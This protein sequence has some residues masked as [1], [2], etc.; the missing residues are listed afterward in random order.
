M[1]N[2]KDKTE[3]VVIVEDGPIYDNFDPDEETSNEDNSSVI[4][5]DGE[6]LEDPTE[7][8]IIEDDVDQDESMLSDADIEEVKREAEAL[9]VKPII[10]NAEI[11]EPIESEFKT[12]A[13]IERILEMETNDAT[14]TI[15]PSQQLD[16][17]IKNLSTAIANAKAD[18]NFDLERT[19]IEVMNGIT[20]TGDSTG[21]ADTLCRN[22]NAKL[23]QGLF[24]PQTGQLLGIR[25]V[26]VGTRAE[27]IKGEVA[28]LKAA[29]ALNLGDVVHVPLP[30]SGFWVTLTPPSE[31]ELIRFYNSMAR[32]KTSLGRSSQG[33]IFGN[34]SVKLNYDLFN[35]IKR[36][37]M[38]VNFK[39]VDKKD[40][41]DKILINDLPILVWG[42]ART[43]YANGF[44]FRRLCDNR[45]GLDDNGNVIP[46]CDDIQK[47]NMSLDK[48]FWLDNN[49]LSETQK[50]IFSKN[51]AK[52]I[53]LN[54]YKVYLE[55]AKYLNSLSF[56]YKTVKIDL[57]QP[58][59]RE[60]FED[61]LQWI[62]D[63][64]DEFDHAVAMN[65][66]TQ[67]EREE[68]L[69]IFMRASMMRNWS[70]YVEAIHIGEN[71]IRDR[72][73]IQTVLSRFGTN[74]DFSAK[75]SEA[76]IEF[77]NKSVIATI[78]IPEYDC[79]KCGQENKG[80]VE[81]KTLTNVIPI[82][83]TNLFFLMFII[84]FQMVIMSTEID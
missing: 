75:F 34:M 24:N 22:E 50:S 71:V 19:L 8:I 26:E 54:D 25:P 45:G 76:I 12:D 29:K 46:A 10:N 1:H 43:I 60:H 44:P 51:R 59:L 57:R 48:L 47:V 33:Y 30:H 6:E 77:R 28:I 80:N 68:N 13:D 27:E 16:L 62:D 14:G 52:S 74:R 81:S 66:F 56:E 64:L 35:L 3:E 21:I 2:E 63:V 32:A 7:P 70:H 53:T 41:D 42:F 17:M 78:G 83:P 23:E 20:Q 40:I 72:E 4:L 69:E 82:S 84:K 58:T 79:P 18:G 9:T 73:T 38:S 31:K 61:G 36:Q 55:Q 15:L 11:R 65:N 67:D 5:L 39:D 49:A 37:I